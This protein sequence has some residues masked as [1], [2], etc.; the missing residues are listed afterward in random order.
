[1]IQESTYRNE[2]PKLKVPSLSLWHKLQEVLKIPCSH[3]RGQFLEE[4]LKVYGDKLNLKAYERSPE[5]IFRLKTAAYEEFR[6]FKDKFNLKEALIV[7]TGKPLASPM[8]G[9]RGECTDRLTEIL[10]EAITQQVLKWLSEVQ[11]NKPDTVKSFK[12]RMEEYSKAKPLRV[13]GS[14]KEKFLSSFLVPVHFGCAFGELILFLYD[15]YEKMPPTKEEFVKAYKSLEVITTYIANNVEIIATFNWRA[16][17]ATD[18]DVEPD[19]I[20]RRPTLRGSLFSLKNGAVIFHPNALSN[21]WL[22][23]DQPLKPWGQVK[24]CPARELIPMCMSWI[25][26][27]WTESLYSPDGN[28]I[29]DFNDGPKLTSNSWDNFSISLDFP[30]T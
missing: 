29:G 8:E 10:T 4:I 11:E 12:E 18:K 2:K 5:E 17:L 27:S 6:S 16:M 14:F 26:N 24:G 30:T 28:W 13:N 19:R 20:N 22:N 21:G 7:V 1:L 15:E 25:C 3:A 23:V 9:L